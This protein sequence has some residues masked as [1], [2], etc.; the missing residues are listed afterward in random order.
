MTYR[1]PAL[2]VLTLA[3]LLV[4][5]DGTVLAVS[6]PFI[7]AG[8]GASATDVLWIGDIY[9]FVLAGLLVTMG[10]IGDRTGHRRLLL[11]AATG[12]ALLSVAA[13]YAPTVG[14]LIGARA[15]LGVSGAALAPSTLALIRGL[16]PK[17]G[18]RSLA[19]GIW[20]AGFSAGSA[21]GPVIGGL[22]LQR[23]WWGSVFLINL[24]VIVLLVAGVVAVVPESSVR[25]TG[26]W[27]L[28]GAGVFL[29]G[30]LALVYALKEGVAHGL[31][32]GIAITGAF[33][34]GAL[35]VFVRRQLRLAA[36]LIDLGL[37][38]S[39]AFSGVIAANLLAMLGLS[40]VVFFLSQFF[41]LVQ[42]FSPMAAGLAEL[43]AAAGAAVFGVLA[44][45]TV[46]YWSP[47]AVLA[48]GLA[49]VGAA[50]A[51]LTVISPST[52]YP[53]LGIALF[54]IGVGLGLV[55]TVA[56][57][58]VLAGVAPE[59]AG[60][61]AAISETSFELGMALGV[62]ALG[63]I[64]AGVYRGLPVPAGIA[65][66]ASAQATDTLS[67]AHQAAALLPPGEARALLSAARS[68]FADGLALA[69]GVGSALLLISA[70]AVWVLLKTPP[71]QR[72]IRTPRH[73]PSLMTH[74]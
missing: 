21:L 69:A 5:I 26:P 63:S 64:V 28:P 24:P 48:G 47:R 68:A 14:I 29:I 20:A 65:D 9:S 17:G 16:F 50:M 61:A 13:A 46:R 41:Q 33:G 40:G 25:G 74:H 56:N 22:L 60:A 12:F 3:V 34:A 44:G 53:Q 72:T 31:D 8:L 58:I 32:T 62:A 7:T 43:P 57:D 2:G 15:L 19:V 67:G 30:M 36:P 6:T 35:A 37:F 51:S 10:S 45:V 1:W 59:R 4:G 54:G 70:V 38:R 39:R 49:L 23:F 11:G 73:D 52:P 66:A 42:G 27:D 71:A 18:D 55:F